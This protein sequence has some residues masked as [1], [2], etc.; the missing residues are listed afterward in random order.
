MLLTFTFKN[1]GPFRDE[2]TFDMRAVKS[3]K[4]HENHCVELFGKERVLKTAAVFGANA[5]GKSS[6]VGAYFYFYSI[7]RDSFARGSE[8]KADGGGDITPPN[9]KVP[10]IRRYYRPFRFSGPDE[11]K[12]TEFDATFSADDGEYRYGFSYDSKHI[13]SEW[14]YFYRDGNARATI[15]LERDA[16]DD[17]EP[18]K[19][20]SSLRREAKKYVKDIPADVLALSFFDG[21]ALKSDAFRNAADCVMSV[22]ALPP[23]GC[24][25]LSNT[26]IQDYFSQ[27]FDDKKEAALLKF[28]GGID[29]EIKGFR[30]KP[31]GDGE[32]VDVFTIH[33]G[34]D[35]KSYEAPIEIESEGTRKLI[36]MYWYL[37]TALTKDATLILD[38]M[39]SELHPLITH[40]LVKLFH[41]SK[42]KGQ[43][44][45]TTHD[46]TLLDKKHL[47][48]DQIWF[49][50]KNEYGVSI[51]RSLSEYSVRNDVDLRSSYLGGAY[52]A[53]PSLRQALWGA[54]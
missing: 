2:A 36:G 12:L 8:G 4:E 27:G 22:L 54:E 13:E 14:L 38:E 51:L 26:L 5:S 45:F 1:F 9:S 10:A 7:V 46:P 48:R 52:D 47:R 33:T 20:G 17:E 37:N 3:Y 11:D 15:I 43:L 19:F 28:L 31:N 35:G 32:D 39:D 29:I 23:I 50:D 25:S 18:I 49:T 21:I 16:S 41:M 40:Y 30:V 42:A 34:P 6:L 44:I 24:G 53:I